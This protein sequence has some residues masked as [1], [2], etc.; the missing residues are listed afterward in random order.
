MCQTNT[1]RHLDTLMCEWEQRS[2]LY[3]RK[4]RQLTELAK[5]KGSEEQ[6]NNR[7]ERIWWYKSK[8]EQFGF[9]EERGVYPK[10]IITRWTDFWNSLHVAKY[11]L[12][13]HISS[14]LECDSDD[15]WN[16]FIKFLSFTI[17]SGLFKKKRLQ[18]ARRSKVLTKFIQQMFHPTLF[19][20]WIA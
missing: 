5:I 3:Y 15:T 18:I 6:I 14:I 9:H 16:I 10:E 19:P 4:H 17:V 7:W 8:N 12:P 2:G 20:K 13:L 1:H 11:L